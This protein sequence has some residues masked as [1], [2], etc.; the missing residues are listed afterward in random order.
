MKI[1]AR[2]RRRHNAY[3]Q[4]L[5]VDAAELEKIWPTVIK[6]MA[7]IVVASAN[8]AIATKLLAASLTTKE[9]K[10]LIETIRSSN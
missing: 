4:R 1:I 6:R 5:K 7:D 3:V 2:A 10:H 8:A 9:M